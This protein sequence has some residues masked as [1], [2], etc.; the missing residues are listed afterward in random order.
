MQRFLT[1]RFEIERVLRRSK[2]VT[3]FVGHDRWTDRREVFVKCIPG[4]VCQISAGFEKRLAWYRSIA[5]PRMGNVVEAGFTPGKDFYYVRDYYPAS[6]KGFLDG[7]DPSTI[8]SRLVGACLLLQTHGIVH[9]RIKPSNVLNQDDGSLR[10][11][12]GGLPGRPVETFSV[13]DV[14]SNAPEILAGGR[15]SLEADLYSL[16]AV[17]YRLFARRDLFEDSNLELLKHKYLHAL[18]VPLSELCDESRALSEIV[19]GLLDK[20]PASRLAAFPSL[21][22]LLNVRY[23]APTQAPFIGRVS[24]FQKALDILSVKGNRTQVVSVEGEAGIGKTRFV[25]ELAF[26]HQ[27][28]AGR[29]L[30]GR[31]YERENRAYEPILQLVGQRLKWRDQKLDNW[32]RNDGGRFGPS[33]KRLFP[34]FDD[35]LSDVPHE[36][37][38]ISAGKMVSDLAGT[39]ISLADLSPTTI[40]LEDVHWI[41]EGSLRILE[42]IYFR[43]GESRLSLV[44]TLRRG[45]A[46]PAMLRFLEEP[47]HPGIDLHRIPLAALDDTSTFDLAQK[48]TDDGRRVPWITANAGGN[49]LFLE[50]CARYQARNLSSLPG[51]V[52][53]ILLQKVGSLKSAD[54]QVAEFLSLFP[55]PLPAALGKKVLASLPGQAVESL[56]RLIESSILC[57]NHD[58]IAF[59]HDGIREA[60]YRNLTRNRRKHYHRI[61]FDL[62]S[63]EGSDKEAA[64]YHAAG[65]GMTE[66]AARAYEHAAFGNRYL[67]NYRTGAELFEL[68]R[69][70]WTQLRKRVA[71]KSQIEHARCLLGVGRYR[72]ARNLL[73]EL[74]SDPVGLEPQ[75]RSRIYTLLANLAESA[76]ESIALLQ[77][78]L[79]SCPP[80]AGVS[81]RE[82]LVPLA[83]AYAIAGKVQEAYSHLRLVE[84]NLQETPPEPVHAVWLSAIKGNIFI[85]LCA[86]KKALKVLH[87]GVERSDLEPIVLNN[88]AVCLEHVGKLSE[89]CVHQAKV[90][91]IVRSTGLMAAELQS[92]ANLGAFETKNGN[93]QEAAKWFR[94][95]GDFCNAMNFYREG[96]RTNL[97]LLDADQAFLCMEIGEYARA[98]R[99]LGSAGRMLKRDT[100]SQKAIWVALRKCE[101]YERTGESTLAKRA[102][103][104]VRNAE[105]FGTDFFSVERT[106]LASSNGK[107]SLND[108]VGGLL[109]ALTLTEST[110][111]TYQ[112]CRVLMELATNL[113]LVGKTDD[114]GKRLAEADR[115][116][117]K[118]GYQ[119]L[120]AKILLMRGMLTSGAQKKEAYFTESYQLASEM[121]LR[122]I[123]AESAFRLGEH[124]LGLTN[125][126]NAR[127]YLS[128]SVDTINNLATEIP[129]RNRNRY[130]NVTWRRQA[131]SILA[132]VDLKLPGSNVTLDN[133][134]PDRRD[135][136]P[137]FKAIYETTIS[138]GA[139]ATTDD[140]V[141]TLHLAI[142][143]TLKCKV[144]LMLTADGKVE[145]YPVGLDDNLSGKI[146]RL[147]ANEKNQPFFGN[148]EVEGAAGQQNHTTAWIPLSSSGS[149]FGGIY[150]DLGQR[151]FREVEIEFLTMLGVIGGNAL[152]AIIHA[153]QKPQRTRASGPRQT[154]CNLS[155]FFRA[156]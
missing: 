3:S 95:A 155:S 110:G 104:S 8:A 21:S 119:P 19:S 103:A 154:D 133:R 35:V 91:E 30:V 44:L 26:L 144:V 54:K 148:Q 11:V 134:A 13:E 74:L 81:G 141:R 100:A 49:P 142:R 67:T 58:E 122:E 139:A 57:G 118:Y 107:D 27:L 1:R 38:P 123:S 114:A 150:V 40:V 109:D 24:E 70:L 146:S 64:G 90:L 23:S 69:N 125:L 31:C 34:D 116:S 138:L 80:T 93:L 153:E 121:G 88:V 137:F 99:L 61:V 32:I 135:D 127:E 29:F 136:N 94:E 124:Q 87:S 5:H 111:T 59:R 22:D 6:A 83:Q 37:R 82:G 75:D 60:I 2:Y 131:I 149:Q 39:V 51:R 130:L 151:K 33:L 62:L 89:A 105:L 66:E 48:L 96:D 25:A 128:R 86:Y 10:L 85:S 120:R 45:M 43:A 46:Q 17:L 108:R 71:P 20:E 53:D 12:D 52:E 97:P 101:L 36:D 65:A 55:K 50:K 16:G 102:W 98:R 132:D 112:R 73:D 78:A 147:Y 76:L 72:K 113:L 129:L 42:Q 145:L 115:L 41:D 47:T 18:P 28:T 152:Y 56:D 14:R 79:D 68:S 156:R 126:L 63:K 140:C 15:P 106:L 143:R 84:R 92:L 4:R 9:G 7:A 77:K 117:R